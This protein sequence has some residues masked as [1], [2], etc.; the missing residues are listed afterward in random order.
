[1]S[2]AQTQFLQL[3]LRHRSWLARHRI[4]DDGFGD[5]PASINLSAQLTMGLRARGATVS[6]RGLAE[7]G[8]SIRQAWDAA[9]GNLINLAA[10]PAGTCFY[11][12]EAR[13]ITSVASAAVQVRTPGAPISAWLAHPRPFTILDGHLRD[14]VGDSIIY[15]LPS[16][17]CLIAAAVSDPRLGKLCDWLRH[18]AENPIIRGG[19]LI[20]AEP[21]VYLNGFPGSPA[22]VMH[23]RTFLVA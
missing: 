7:L 21:L 11:L 20:S 10:G 4:S 2:S 9:A 8:L 15:L 14:Q 23:R 22:S 5:S 18:T 1:M 3:R 12:R 19:E 16:A 17:D 13:T 6:Y